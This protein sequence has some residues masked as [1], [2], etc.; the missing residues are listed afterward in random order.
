M[1]IDNAPHFDPS[2][3]VGHRKQGHKPRWL[4]RHPTTERQFEVV[5][6]NEKNEPDQ[7]WVHELI[8]NGR[9]MIL[10]ENQVTQAWEEEDLLA[11]KGDPNGFWNQVRWAGI[12][13]NQV[14]M[15]GAG[16]SVDSRYFDSLEDCS[17]AIEGSIEKNVWFD[18]HRVLDAAEKAKLRL[19]ELKSSVDYWQRRVQTLERCKQEARHGQ[20]DPLKGF[21]NGLGKPLS[22]SVRHEVMSYIYGPNQKDWNRVRHC[23]VTPSTTLWQAWVKYDGNANVAGTV[24]FPSAEMLKHALGNLLEDERTEAVERLGTAREALVMEFPEGTPGSGHHSAPS[25]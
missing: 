10:K 25:S 22:D 21:C 24:G 20:G 17:A 8:P 4:Y 11:F 6:V 12:N 2:H 5:Q 7:F 14:V 1:S 23:L 15:I 3:P 13:E 19:D 18:S 9:M 16:F